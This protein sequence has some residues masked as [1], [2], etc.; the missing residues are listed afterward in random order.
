MSASDE[1]IWAADSDFDGDENENGKDFRS[2]S[3]GESGGGGS[4]DFNRLRERMAT[5]GFN[6]GLDATTSEELLQ[7]KFNEGFVSASRGGLTVG[8]ITGIIAA[9]LSILK[10]RAHTSAKTIGKNSQKID[11]AVFLESCVTQMRLLMMK[12]DGGED[13]EGHEENIKILTKL[14]HDIFT[15]SPKICSHFS[16]AATTF[17]DPNVNANLRLSTPVYL[18]ASDLDGTLFGAPE[19]V[20]TVRNRIAF[21]RL[22]ASGM[23]IALCSG[24]SSFSMTGALANLGI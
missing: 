9:E 6:D 1:D 22:Y 7:T 23:P 14:I 19:H 24:R 15:Q 17:E 11:L 16:K 4:R 20:P 10:A 8:L 18:V 21:R 12:N 2:E 13:D 5:L 3:G